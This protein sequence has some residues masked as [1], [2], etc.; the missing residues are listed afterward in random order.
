VKNFLT[1]YNS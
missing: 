1:L